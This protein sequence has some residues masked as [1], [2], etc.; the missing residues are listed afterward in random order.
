MIIGVTGIMVQMKDKIDLDPGFDPNYR[1]PFPI[2]QDLVVLGADEPK[3]KKI[4]WIMREKEVRMIHFKEETWHCRGCSS[5]V[6]EN[7]GQECRMDENEKEFW[8]TKEDRGLHPEWKAAWPL[9]YVFIPDR[10]WWTCGNCDRELD[11]NEKV[12]VNAVMDSINWSMAVVGDNWNSGV[13]IGNI[14]AIKTD[15][16]IV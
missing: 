12:V 14:E 1:F 10:T 2:R 13:A 7:H 3:L 8:T 11:S 5:T 16:F 6:A 15:K 4:G 9:G